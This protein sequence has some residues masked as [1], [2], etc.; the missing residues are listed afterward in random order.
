MIEKLGKY[1]LLTVL[2][3]GN[4]GIVYLAKDTLMRREVAL[5]VIGMDKLERDAYFQEAQLQHRLEHSNIVTIY[6]VDEIDG[7]VV[8][9]MEYVRGQTLR[10]LFGLRGASF[11]GKNRR[12][13][14]WGIGGFGVC[15]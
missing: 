13:P 8:I 9:A 10:A 6:S 14:G 7:K 1:E 2:G 3:H 11:S 5:K 12:N 4:F 15:A